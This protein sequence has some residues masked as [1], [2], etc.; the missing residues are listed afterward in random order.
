VMC[1]VC[2]LQVIKSQLF[3]VDRSEFS[4]WLCGSI[5][6]TVC[7]ISAWRK[8]ATSV[9]ATVIVTAVFFKNFVIFIVPVR[10]LLGD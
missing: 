9:T 7:D 4:S 2:G 1:C 5:Q 6:R 3:T 10:P 8:F